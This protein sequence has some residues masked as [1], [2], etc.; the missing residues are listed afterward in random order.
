M[1]IR[2]RWHVLF[3]LFIGLYI[4]FLLFAN[5]YF[6]NWFTEYSDSL[7]KEIDKT[8]S[9]IIAAFLS[10]CI[11]MYF[12]SIIDKQKLQLEE[13][14]T[15]LQ[16]VNQQLES[17]ANKAAHDFKSPI[18][19]SLNM[20][21]LAKESEDLNEARKYI[22]LEESSLKGLNRFINKML[23]LSK[24]TQKETKKEPVD[25]EELFHETTENLKYMNNGVHI[26]FIFES[27]TGTSVVF[28]DRLK[29]EIIFNNI[30]S[31]A[32]KY[33]DNFK[34]KSFSSLVLK[35][36]ENKHTLE[37]TDNGVGISKEIVPKI[38]NPFF[39]GS[40]H[41]DSTG[42]GL[43]SVNEAIKSLDGHIEA[44]SEEGKGTTFIITL[45]VIE[46]S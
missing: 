19:A 44:Q 2:K 32:I 29:M 5:H 46:K 4:S 8:I 15:D 41:P 11:L 34:E 12:K 27:F 17:F 16:Q 13:R 20:I 22:D 38:F 37:F 18:I 45:P 28:T 31:N 40:N 9:V 21:Q 42:I 26:E 35:Q 24:S 36:N 14:N 6:I 3:T 7:S 23:E 39:K 25:I 43:H 10:A 30:L 1:I 33:K